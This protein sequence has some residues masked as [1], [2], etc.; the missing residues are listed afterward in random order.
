M[1]SGS[2]DEGLHQAFA[3]LR[4]LLRDVIALGAVQQ[5]LVGKNFENLIR[6]HW[7]GKGGDERRRFSAVYG[8]ADCR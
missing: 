7:W 5:A 2:S 8:A 6:D 4:T 3:S 1:G